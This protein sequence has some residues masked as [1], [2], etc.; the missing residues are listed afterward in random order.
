MKGVA[1]VLFFLKPEDKSFTDEIISNLKIFMHL[2]AF[3][4]KDFCF[5]ELLK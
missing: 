1:K 3:S 5:L 4:V 2:K